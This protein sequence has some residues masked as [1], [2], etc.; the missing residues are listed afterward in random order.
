MYVSGEPGS[1]GKAVKEPLP[2]TPNY[3]A[4]PPFPYI[5][6]SS[7]F[8]LPVEQTSSSSPCV[9]KPPRTPLVHDS[10]N[11]STSISPGLSDNELVLKVRVADS[12]EK[13]FIELEMEKSKLSFQY[14]LSTICHELSVNPSLVLKLRKLPNTI[15]RKDKDVARFVDFQE[16]ELVLKSRTGDSYSPRQVDIMY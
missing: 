13:D 5:S 7:S 4:H 3:L 9:H 10:H 2:I 15:V 11:G 12:S 6:S 1:E 14:V 8:R 16:L